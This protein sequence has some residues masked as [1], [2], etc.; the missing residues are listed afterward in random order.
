VVLFGDVDGSFGTGTDILS[1]LRVVSLPCGG[2]GSLLVDIALFVD[3]PDL[4]LG[5]D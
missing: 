4:S 2:G 1:G 5:T 3:N